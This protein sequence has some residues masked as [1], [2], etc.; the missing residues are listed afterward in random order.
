M[1]KIIFLG[2][3]LACSVATFATTLP[4]AP[5]KILKIFHRDFP[6]VQNQSISLVGDSYMV[7][8]KNEDER[9]A[10]RVYYNT[11]GDILQTIKYYSAEN[12]SP[13][14]RSRVNSK[15]KDKTITS[16]TDVTNSSGHFY[17]IVMEDSKSW[18]YLDVNEK[19][20]I[21]VQKRLKKQK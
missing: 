4:D 10:Y 5:D 19:G 11:N 16:V 15:Y 6:N 1:K 7:Y 13:F 14:I 21:Q 8:F 12:L 9:T 3:I 20:S 17:Q 2:L 18:I